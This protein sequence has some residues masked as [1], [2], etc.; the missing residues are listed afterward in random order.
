MAD[1]KGRELTEGTAK[2]LRKASIAF[3]V[4]MTVVA[5]F[6]MVRYVYPSILDGDA[7]KLSVAGSFAKLLSYWGWKLT[8]IG[9]VDFLIG[10]IHVLVWIALVLA[11]IVIDAIA[12]A[13]PAVIGL[14]L[15]LLFLLITWGSGEA[16]AVGFIIPVFLA[17]IAVIFGVSLLISR[18][19]F[20]I[21]VAVFGFSA[22]SF[23]Y[24]VG[25]LGYKFYMERLLKRGAMD[26]N[27]EV[28]S[29]KEEVEDMPSKLSEA[30]NKQE[31][32]SLKRL[33]EYQVLYPEISNEEGITREIQN[34]L[35]SSILGSDYDGYIAEATKRF[36]MR[37]I[38]KTMDSQVE[39]LKK[40]RALVEELT[41]IQKAKIA[42]SESVYEGEMSRTRNEIRGEQ[43]RSGQLKERIRK[44][45]EIKDKK[46][47]LE[48]AE[49]EAQIQEAKSKKEK[50]IVE[51]ELANIELELAKKR[52]QPAWR[53]LSPAERSIQST[54]DRI[55]MIKAK[56]YGLDL[57]RKAMEE[58]LTGVSDEKIKREKE[59]LWVSYI[60]EKKEE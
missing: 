50:L 49:I 8:G 19:M 45:E 6:L 28:I 43:L 29:S 25:F 40:V 47:E 14:F 54:K 11:G 30:L 16:F 48:E 33:A 20:R 23:E 58:D 12:T 57:I 59:R 2:T 1:K 4:V 34:V 36:A 42:L 9:L 39:I 60:M 15:G 13:I 38:S 31:S 32:E 26:D 35:G 41:A 18:L 17:H 56:S 7:Y 46:L 44:E 52:L 27:T 55:E 3:A 24:S 10:V 53:G 37:Q 22:K 51:T 21:F 5:V